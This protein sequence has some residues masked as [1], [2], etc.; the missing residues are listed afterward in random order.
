[1]ITEA[2]IDEILSR[3][4]LG[5]LS[6]EEQKRIEEQYFANDM[7]FER[8][9][10]AEDDLIERYLRDELGGE[11]RMQ[12]ES[13]FLCSRRR[14]ERV[15]LIRSVM[16]PASKRDLATHLRT[17]RRE[18]RADRWKPLTGLIGIRPSRFG[19]SIA[20]AILLILAAG[21]L[22]ITLILRP[23]GQLR[24][25]TSA[26]RIPQL[27][28]KVPSNRDALSDWNRNNSITKQQGPDTHGE[29]E[30]RAVKPVVPG[31]E[32]STPAAIVF[33]L[34]GNS[35]RGEGK[36]PRLFI[37][38]HIQVVELQVPIEELA[39]QE[40]RLVLS[41]ENEE[42]W[43]RN[44]PASRSLKIK[45]S[46]SLTIPAKLFSRGDYKLALIGI[47]GT[48]SAEEIGMYFFRVVDR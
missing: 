6:E 20:I 23:E 34:S 5:R 25:G 10:L 2:N 32:P 27:P 40:Y 13:Y 12:F 22:L 9:R 15:E 37:P 38:S 42:I 26:I 3:Y 47:N 30:K 11:D 43:N 45:R 41:S 7:V 46:V 17:T 24:Q 8:L 4:L 14:V 19:L 35:H 29:D 44:V 31:R 1:M 39:Y 48:G 28:I 18:K 16:T 36:T 21:A 33:A